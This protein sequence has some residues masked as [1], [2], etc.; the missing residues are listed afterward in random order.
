MTVQRH[1]VELGD[2]LDDLVL[3]NRGVEEGE[4]VIVRGLQQVRPGS[5]VKTKSLAAE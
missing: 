2:R 3:V 4:Q 5:V 1:N